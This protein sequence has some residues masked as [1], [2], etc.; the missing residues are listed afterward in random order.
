MPNEEAQ[1]NLLNKVYS[2][3]DFDYESLSYIEAHGTGTKVGDPIE[4]SAI[5]RSLASK[6]GT[7]LPIGSIKSNIGH[8]E[9]AAGLAGLI[10][11]LLCIKHGVVPPTI[12]CK[13]LNKDIDFD[14]ANITVVRDNLE[15]NKPENDIVVGINSFGFGGT[16]AHAVITGYRDDR[17]TRDIKKSYKGCSLP[18]LLT[19]HEINLHLMRYALF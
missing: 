13:V 11:G 19:R 16:N 10:K 12:N 7:P 18:I 9:P 2:Q 15:L 8:L 5:S 3:I 14:K 1:Y 4:V 17:A 6:R